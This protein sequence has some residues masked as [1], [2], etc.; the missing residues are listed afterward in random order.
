MTVARSF[1]SAAGAA[2]DRRHVVVI[3]AGAVG[4]AT[5]I[6][7]LRAGLRVTVVE[8]G[9]PGGPH[10]T[11]YGNAGWLSSHSVVPPALP[12]AWLKVPGWLA[13]PLGPLALRWRYLPR[14]LPWLLRYLASGW[15]EARVQRTANALRTLLADAPVL[16]ARLAAEAGVPQL[17]ER[18][19]LLH[20]Y[21]SRAEFDGDA[22]GWRVRRRTGVQWEE[23]P[24]DELRRRE[25]DLHAR[26]TFGIFVPEAGHC[27]DPGS[28]VAALARHALEAGAERIATRATGFRIEGGRLR[29]VLTEAGEIAC[30]GAAIC[31]GARSGP[32]A[33]AA[34]STV[35]LESERGYHVV[36]EDATSGP[37]TPTM[38]ADGKLIAHWM[39]GGLRAAGQ[40][41]I[42]GLEAAPDW[43]RAEI[44][45]THLRSMFPSLARPA[46]GSPSTVKHWLGHRPSL[47]DGL[48]CI[49]PAAASA[50]VVL[51][52]GHG[53]V[54]LC[55]S[56]R[57]GRLA[58]QLL[59]GIAP[60][61]PLKPFDPARF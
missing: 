36:V 52:F 10:A 17:V 54:G 55:G 38:V 45:H 44:L 30:D 24:Q 29:A 41:E 35:P 27:R 19:G 37:R 26:Y 47:P 43:R 23:W 1:S 56:A 57:T 53:H 11:S 32:L 33:A 14:A 40:V 3:G 50:D 39:D 12:G 51:A 2:D 42:A 20:A 25:P 5:A 49:G 7:A 60:E 28:Y 13:D 8:P 31:A 4:S 21:L 59:A 15:T 48:P 18:R 22:L 61:I 34:G 9:E 58:A 16:H 46:P 6:E